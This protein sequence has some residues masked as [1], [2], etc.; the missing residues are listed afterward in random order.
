MQTLDLLAITD[1]KFLTAAVVLAFAIIIYA[2][3]EDDNY[4]P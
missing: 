3:F 2:I 4:R 1:A